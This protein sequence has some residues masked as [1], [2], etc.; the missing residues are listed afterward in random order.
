MKITPHKGYH[1]TVLP[2]GIR[3]IGEEIPD[4]NSVTVGVFV[5]CGGRDEPQD[6][7][8]IAHFTEHMLFKGTK[9][10]TA[11][12]I[13]K[14]IDRT[15]GVINAYTDKEY[16][17]YYVK[18]IKDKLE[19]G[20]ELLADIFLNS[21]FPEEELKRE[22]DVVL[23][24][25]SMVEDTPDDLIHDLLLQSVF[26]KDGL[27]YSLLGSEDSV[28]SFTRDK[29]ANFVDN[30]YQN[31]RIVIAAA[32]SFK[33]N[34]FLILS[35]KYFGDRKR[36]QKTFLRANEMSGENIKISKSHLYQ[37]HTAIGFKTVSIYDNDRYP[38]KVL[39]YILGAGMSSL[40]FQE[41]R[42]KTGYAYSVYSFTHEYQDTGYLEIYYGTSPKYN[43]T[44]MN[45]V[46]E[47]LTN[48]A[49]GE[50]NPEEVEYAKEQ[51]RGYSLI[52]L[53]SSNAR[54]SYNAKV[55][56]YY[57]DFIP[58][59]KELEN[60]KNVSL[61]DIVRVANTYLS[62]DKAK[63]AIISPVEDDENLKN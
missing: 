25:I 10:R 28:K 54:F 14:T 3:I 32:G 24:E 51:I 59:E 57:N 55:E 37:V 56:L 44:C 8:G 7:R 48:F 6:Q 47:I 35:E 21:I 52:A 9:K 12:D 36:S 58:I 16:T 15:G 5:F 1:K 17:C 34:D 11:L 20:I 23:Q 22:K 18:I 50:I 29:V 46:K 2:N 60:L 39:N 61:D 62:L 63:C 42:E 41:L 27:G 38:L 53:D 30:Y 4:Y 40:L 43:S 49:K 33:W 45:K 31:D 19:I 26:G 13:S